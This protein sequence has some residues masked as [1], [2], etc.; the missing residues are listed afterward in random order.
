MS[1]KNKYS[2][3]FNTALR[4]KNILM[5]KSHS[6]GIGDLLRSSAA[7]R[8]LK[9]HW[10]DVNLHLVF[11]S[12]HPGYAVEELMKVH[13]LLKSATF[14]TLR[15]GSPH[16]KDA[17]KISHKIL[18]VQLRD[19]TVKINPDLII[20]F[21]SS[22]IRTSLLTLIAKQACS[23][24]T[25][26]IAQF[27]GRRF[28]YDFTASNTDYFAKKRGLPTPMDYTNRDFVALSAIGIERKNRPIELE[29]SP[30]GMLYAENLLKKLPSNKQVIGLNIGCGTP[31]AIHKRPNIDDLV[32]SI[33]LSLNS[34]SHTLILSGAANEQDVNL[35]FID[36][37]RRKWGDTSHIVDLAGK[38]TMSTL[39]GL[40]HACA[41]FISTDSGP[42]HMSV[43]MKKPTIAWLTYNESTSFH[44]HPWCEIL[45][46]PTPEKFKFAINKLASENQIYLEN[47]MTK[48]STIA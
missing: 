27:P 44:N 5:I 11:L 31:D 41:I 19:L 17:K 29:A 30:S 24:K 9:D 42:Y 25:I 34:I 14:I 22:G 36:C 47:L 3:V 23:A 1:A 45:I 37:Y 4:P 32:D 38:T 46:Q 12:K 13:H 2:I 28:F 10:P 16:I 8:A 43:A 39:S 26:G 40:I 33:G 48:T 35:E 18:R 6:M 7:W 21:E 20:D 15:E